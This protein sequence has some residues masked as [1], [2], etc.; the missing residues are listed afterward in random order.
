MAWLVCRVALIHPSV[1]GLRILQCGPRRMGPCLH[2]QRHSCNQAGTRLL[3]RQCAD[4]E[5][6]MVVRQPSRLLL[7]HNVAQDNKLKRLP[8][9]ATTKMPTHRSSAYEKEPETID[10]SARTEKWSYGSRLVDW[11]ELSHGT[12]DCSHIQPKAT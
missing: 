9:M 4:T 1:V 11:E 12:L 2:R 5:E 7:S 10:A 3:P 6:N 8:G